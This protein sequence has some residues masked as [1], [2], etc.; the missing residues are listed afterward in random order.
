MV[1]EAMY[2]DD[3]HKIIGK[4][5]SQIVAPMVA[6]AIGNAI[7]AVYDQKKTEWVSPTLKRVSGMIKDL[8][9][10]VDDEARILLERTAEFEVRER[11]VKGGMI[12]ELLIEN[13]IKSDSGQYTCI[14]SNPYGTAQRTFLLHV[15]DAPGK[16]S[17]VRVVE[18][19]SRSL[20]ATWRLP[21][22]EQK[23]IHYTVQFKKESGMMT[24]E[25]ED[26]NV[27]H[28]N[29]VT[30]SNLDPASV[31]SIKVKAENQLGAGEPSD[32]IQ[33]IIF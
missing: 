19:T 29:H 3:L 14:A 32:I 30:I 25:W 20:K 16:P 15:E 12:S 11:Q 28:D 9:G 6:E 1:K 17:E 31:Y 26:I 23:L 24:D 33:V 8:E 7:G 22:D 10:K 13:S 2:T 4:M 5:V 18:I 21:R 27:G